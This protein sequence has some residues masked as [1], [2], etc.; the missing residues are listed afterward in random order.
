MADVSQW[1]AVFTQSTST[2]EPAT[3]PTE[4]WPG[5]TLDD[6]YAI[7]F[8][9]ISTRVAA[10]EA[11]RAIKLGLTQQLEQDQ[12]SIPHPTFGTLTDSMLLQPGDAFQVSRG[13]EPKVEAEIV[14]II[15]QDISDRLVSVD[16]LVSHV[17]SVHAGIE[18]L[19]SRYHQGQ[20]H[21]VDAVADNQ[22]A[23]SGVWLGEGIAVRDID[24][25]NESATLTIGGVEKGSGVA[26]R[27][28]GNPLNAVLGAVNERVRLGQKVP[29]GLAI[30]SGNLCQ[31]A[32]PVSAGD[33]VEVTFSS[34]G[35][36]SLSVTD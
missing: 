21:P 19:D 15:G 20:F 8:A 12:W 30:F 36:L 32:V 17:A 16:E 5:V 7:Q 35:S 10:G 24:L 3:R 27:I 23:L 1:A 13:R 4:T 9:T 26:S 25:V 22:S 29:A 34:L 18:I 6:A 33:D 2:G 14:V 28:L 31:A 11:I